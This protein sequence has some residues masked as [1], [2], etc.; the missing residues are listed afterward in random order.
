ME[1]EFQRWVASRPPLIQQA[2][3]RWPIG[4]TVL[5]NGERLYLIGWGETDGATSVD[6]LR[7]IFSHTN[8]FVDYEAA[9]S[10]RVYVCASHLPA[11]DDARPHLPLWDRRQ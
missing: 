3:A 10:D 2:I 5:H 11:S 7:L 9:S 6:D 4:T 8:P 1:K